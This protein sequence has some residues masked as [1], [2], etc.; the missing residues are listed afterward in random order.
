MEQSTLSG[1]IEENLMKISSCQIIFL[2][3][4]AQSSEKSTTCEY[5]LSQN[6]EKILTTAPLLC[7][8]FGHAS[9]L[10]ML[11]GVRLGNPS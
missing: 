7:I 9:M 1:H 11:D 8:S 4:T 10:L 3:S 2:R 6:N 5:N